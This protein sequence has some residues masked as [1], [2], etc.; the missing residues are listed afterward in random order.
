MNTQKN[1]NH[2]GA[3]QEVGLAHCLELAAQK[4]EFWYDMTLEEGLNRRCL[5][6]RIFTSYYGMSAHPRS[7]EMQFLSRLLRPWLKLPSPILARWTSSSQTAWITLCGGFFDYSEDF[8]EDEV[9]RS[10]KQETFLFLPGCPAKIMKDSHLTGGAIL[11][12][13]IQHS[14]PKPRNLAA[15]PWT[16]SCD[17]IACKKPCPWVLL[18]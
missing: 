8:M 17:E 18:H 12:N 1:R 13:L 9:G 4:C 6:K 15:T 5:Q 16:A 2:H 11:Y 3:G 14:S 10:I 7:R